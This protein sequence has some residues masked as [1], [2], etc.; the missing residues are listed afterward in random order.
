MR[1][2]AKDFVD[3]ILKNTEETLGASLN[4]VKSTRAAFN[5]QQKAAQASAQQAQK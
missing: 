1:Q 4:E 2:S 3:S 5:Q